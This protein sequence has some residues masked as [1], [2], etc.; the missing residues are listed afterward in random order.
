MINPQGYNRNLSTYIYPEMNN[1]SGPGESP[2]KIMVFKTHILLLTKTTIP[3]TNRPPSKNY[4][5]CG[6]GV[7]NRTVAWVLSR[8]WPSSTLSVCLSACLSSSCTRS[9]LIFCQSFHKQQKVSI[10]KVWMVSVFVCDVG[11]G[12]YVSVEDTSVSQDTTGNYWQLKA[13]KRVHS[14]RGC[15]L[16]CHC[17]ELNVEYPWPGAL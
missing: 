16:E 11:I 8:M 9:D 12:M 14:H 5:K 10:R 7:V 1:R 15:P 13:K 4:N 17:R 2:L 6:Y 3:V